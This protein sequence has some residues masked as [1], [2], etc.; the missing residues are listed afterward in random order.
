VLSLRTQ[1]GID[2]I[3]LAFVRVFSPWGV[4]ECALLLPEQDG[5]LS[6]RADAPIRVESFTLTPEEMV[7]AKQVFAEG[8]IRE[9]RTDSHSASTESKS[10]LRLV[11]LKAENE[12]LGLLCLRIEHGVSWFAN[13]QRMQEELE[14]PTDQAIF[15]LTF[16]DQVVRVIE[17]ARLHARPIS[18][19]N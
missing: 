12:V 7:V 3:A 8:K 4:H 1:L 16:L 15:F 5:T 14:Q 9:V 19:N 13:S 17:L 11:P 6:I 2:S 18:N 10:V